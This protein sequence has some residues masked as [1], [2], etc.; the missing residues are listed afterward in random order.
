M[1]EAER[2][3]AER[4]GELKKELERLEEK[5]CKLTNIETKDFPIVSVLF[6]LAQLNAQ[7]SCE[8]DQSAGNGIGLS[9]EQKRQLDGLVGFVTIFDEE[10]EIVLQV[11]GFASRLHFSSLSTKSNDCNLK[12]ARLRGEK[13]G[14]YLRVKLRDSRVSIENWNASTT[15]ASYAKMDQN[16]CFPYEQGRTDMSSRDLHALNQAVCITISRR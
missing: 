16:R 1:D 2:A 8:L 13:V 12:A 4:T 3:S 9:I 14:A 11:K 10:D 15:D 6:P 5:L 7:K